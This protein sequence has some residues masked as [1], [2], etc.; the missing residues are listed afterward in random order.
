[1]SAFHPIAT[2]FRIFRINPRR[3]WTAP[4]RNR[5]YRVASRSLPLG[6]PVNQYR[7]RMPI[8]SQ[9]TSAMSTKARAVY[10]NC[11]I[12]LAQDAQGWLVT[13]ITHIVSGSSLLP[14]GVRYLDRASAEQYA[15][16]AIDAQL[17]G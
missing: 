15:K 17:S 5:I 12:E 2:E 4:R 9:E 7:A 14:P 6:H 10:R 16:A 8:S 13:G 11:L 1:M 3:A